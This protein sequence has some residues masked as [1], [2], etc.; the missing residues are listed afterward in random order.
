[1]PKYQIVSPFP[2]TQLLE[3]IRLFALAI[4][5]GQVTEHG[6]EALSAG[7]DAIFSTKAHDYSAPCGMLGYDLKNNFAK[8]L[9]VVEDERK[10]ARELQEAQKAE[11]LDQPA[12][13]EPTIDDII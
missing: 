11:E 6:L 4:E 8:L 1:M 13:A 3:A 7:C 2:I 9:R 5:N 10:A 12:E